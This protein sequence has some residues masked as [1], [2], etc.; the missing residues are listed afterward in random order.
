MWPD[1][2]TS[3]DRVTASRSPIAQRPSPRAL[4]AAASLDR[5]TRSADSGTQ[6]AGRAAE[7]RGERGFSTPD[8]QRPAVLDDG[9]GASFRIA[10]H[11][12][13]DARPRQRSRWGPLWGGAGRA[14][15]RVALRRRLAVRAGISGRASNA[16]AI[17]IAYDE[18][19]SGG[20]VCG[21]RAP[22]ARG[23]VAAPARRATDAEI[24]QRV[25]RDL[26]GWPV[27]RR[28]LRR[29]DGAQGQCARCAPL[30][31]TRSEARSGRR[32]NGEVGAATPDGR[33]H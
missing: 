14:V 17:T 19:A 11:L 5:G 15:Q 27:G 16:R 33:A 1:R 2:R 26:D 13:R 21:D 3:L 9:R 31:G 12:P 6:P 30:L 20:V 8:G 4:P 10:A 22:R 24:W 32:S 29:H 18:G 25:V 28:A 7:L 23:S